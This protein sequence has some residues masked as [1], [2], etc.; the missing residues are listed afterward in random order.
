MYRGMADLHDRKSCDTWR[1]GFVKLP[2]KMNGECEQHGTKM[3]DGTYR[4]FVAVLLGFIYDHEHYLSQS[5]NTS[6]LR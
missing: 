4:L 1:S 5:W 2:Q 6:Q 3:M